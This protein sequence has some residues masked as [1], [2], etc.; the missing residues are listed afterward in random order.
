[1]KRWQGGVSMI[2]VLVSLVII[3]IGVLGM[4]ALQTRSVALS[5]DSVQR[6]N[7][8]VLANDLLE[9]MRSNRDQ[10][11]ASDKVKIDGAYIKQPGTNFRTKA[12]DAGKTCLTRDRSAGGETVAG[13]DLGCWLNQVKALLPVTD[14]L[15]ASSFAVCPASGVPKLPSSDPA[16]NTTP[17]G[18]CETNA[19]APVMVVVAWQD[20]SNDSLN[21]PKGV[22]Y[23]ALRSEL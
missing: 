11:V 22:C 8:M 7:A 5:Q 15:I 12:L 4:V 16:G 2:E 3:C 14:A 18:A 21:C 13:Q 6:S 17:L 19:V 10:V 23:Y 9:L 1:M 20:V